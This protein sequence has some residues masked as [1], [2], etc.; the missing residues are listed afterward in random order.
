MQTSWRLL[1]CYATN[2]WP[3]KKELLDPFHLSTTG[4]DY[5]GPLYVKQFAEVDDWT[6]QDDSMKVWVCLFTC[7]TVCAIHLKLVEDMSADEFLLYLHQ[8]ISRRRTPQIIISGNAQQFKCASTTLHKV[9]RE[10]VTD[11]KVNDFV[12]KYYIKWRFIAELA[13]WIYE[14]LVG[15]TKRALR[16]TIGTW[17]LAQKQLSTVLAK[18]EAVINSCP[19]VYVKLWYKFQ[20]I[21]PH[22]FYHYTQTTSFPILLKNLIQSL[23]IQR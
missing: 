8:F 13:S 10:V 12:T 20:H 15:L 2:A 6:D 21:F 14:R 19:L 16:K 1:F 4:L 23:M 7:M 5:L 3:T 22:I 9:W 17:S 11:K 18:V